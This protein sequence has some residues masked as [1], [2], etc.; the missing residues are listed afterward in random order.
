MPREGT[1][2]LCPIAALHILALCISSIWLFLSCILYN[3]LVRVNK[4]IFLSSVCCF[5]ELSNPRRLGL[6]GPRTCSWLG[7]NVGNL[8]TLFVAGTLSGCGL[9]GLSP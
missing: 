6:W 1:E 8:S 5:S 4:A 9:V 2:A 7:R 3:K